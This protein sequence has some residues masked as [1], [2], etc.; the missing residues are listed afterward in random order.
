MNI[1]DF[2]VK[3]TVDTYEWTQQLANGIDKE[4][5]D[6]LPSTLETNI[7]WQIG[8]LLMSN[9]YHS[10]IVINGHDSEVL[11]KVPLKEYNNLFSGKISTEVLPKNNVGNIDPEKL[12]QD[13]NLIQKKSIEQ[14]S[15]LKTDDFNAPLEQS[16]TPHPIAKSKGEALDWNIK[17]T[18][19]HCGQ[20]A[21]LQRV[22]IN[23]SFDFEAIKN[24]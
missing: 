12:H 9:Y 17:H 5:W 19:W 21:M 10:I 20:I 7:T 18:M 13:L 1:F 11:E 15:Q 2:L 14:I 24:K 6:I 3:Q 8:H 23:K 22:I 16:K 4:K